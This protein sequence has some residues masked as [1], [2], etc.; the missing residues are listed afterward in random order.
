ML[1]VLLKRSS[2]ARVTLPLKFTLH[3]SPFKGIISLEEKKGSLCIVLCK[4]RE[5]NDL[6]ARYF[7]TSP[8]L[9]IVMACNVD[10]YYVTSLHRQRLVLSRGLLVPFIF[11]TS[12]AVLLM[13]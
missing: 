6:D 8:S 7:R 11:A 13:L 12:N 3:R 1:P 4:K 5:Y 10:Q 9:P 2:F